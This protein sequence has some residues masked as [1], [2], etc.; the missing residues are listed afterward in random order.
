MDD[1]KYTITEHLGE[2]RGRLI[3][4]FGGIV[5]TTV[6]SLAFS[7]TLLEH[8]VAP[9]LDVLEARS[10]IEAA[11]VHQDTKAAA[12][13]GERLAS[14]E[15]VNFRGHASDLDALRALAQ[16]A[17]EARRPL[18]IVLVSSGALGEDG[19]LAVDVL[20]GIEPAP[21]VAYMVPGPSAPVVA[22]L[23]L[24]GA[25]VIIDPPR[26][27]VLSRVLR[28][29]AAAAG[30]ASG[31]DKLVVLS[32]LEP[33]FAYLKIA[34]VCGLFL[35]CPIWLYQSWRFVAPGL[36]ANEKHFVA[37]TLISGSMLFIGGG[38][39]AYFA[40]FPMMFDVLVN[41]MMPDMLGSAFTV[42]KYLSL[43]LR[44]TVA[45]GVVFELPLALALMAMVGVVT[46][47]SLR[48]FRKYAIVTS[49]VVAAILT[50]A[51]PL[52]QL[53][54][55]GPLV[56]FYEIGILAA[57]VLQKRRET[58]VADDDEPTEPAEDEPQSPDPA[59]PTNEA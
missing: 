30:K 49:F 8:A 11:V 51:D 41:Q 5:L 25:N 38:L 39:F 13:L 56:V 3:K 17:I 15:R 45:F 58:A 54:M 50:P 1:S 23:M 37:P 32:P 40:M 48:R 35:A 20:D 31:G 14:R 4:S 28:R 26:N 42:D 7:P 6:A 33:F 53:M 2:L 47:D 34:L 9:L 10:R 12:K 27:A 57:A 22:E 24:E 44:V 36:Y 59:P 18:D 43:L 29:A 16:E 46:A 19:A 52:S 55:A 21:Y